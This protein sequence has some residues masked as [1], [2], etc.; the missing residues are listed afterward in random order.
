MS[1]A[2]TNCGLQHQCLCDRIPQLRS[3]LQLSLL[4][5]ENEYQRD[6]NTGR[7]L[8]AAVPGC[9]DFGWSRVEPSPSLQQRIADPNLYSVLVYPD[10]QSLSP[11]QV[12]H[13][14]R[15][16]AQQPHFIVLD[17][18]WQEAKKMVRKSPWLDTLPSMQ[19]MPQQQSAYQLRR[20]QSDGHLCTLEVGC[21]LLQMLDEADNATQLIRFFTEFMQVYQADKSGHRWSGGGH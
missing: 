21:E 1:G 4:M 8:R 10:E 7:W 11:Q 3:Q 13:Q 5:H 6:T 12:L 20:N 19:L 15:H 9:Q 14:A 2:C 16:A 18:T 17:G